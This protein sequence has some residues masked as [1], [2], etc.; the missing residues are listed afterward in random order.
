MNI[1]IAGASGFIG[2]ALISSLEDKHHITV[3]GRN[4]RKL[5]KLFKDRV[6]IS[7][8]SWDE[9]D[10]LDAHSFDAVINLCGHNISASRWN[11][12]VKALLISSRVQTSTRLIEWIKKQ[13]A[14]THIYSA[15]AVGIY[16]KQANF[17]VRVF[18]ESH[19]VYKLTADDFLN[20]IGIAWEQSLQLAKEAGIPLTITRF[21]VVLDKNHGMLK[22]LR[23]PF[24]MHLGS[25][26]GTGRQVISWIHIDDLVRAY[27]FL[28][29]SPELT[30][31]FNLCSPNPLSQKAFAETFAKVL[32]R[33]LFLKIPAFLIRAIFGEMGDCLLLNGQRVA[34]KRLLEEGFVFKYGTLQAAL[35]H[36]FDKP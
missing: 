13:S 31:C 34:P 5:Q 2:Q 10:A 20:H 6:K 23:L 24:S 15:S 26:L 7:T 33:S 9:L 36:E 30:G 11:K 22:K 8:H 12:R 18:D 21:G 1:L 17:D 32:H 3:L 19:P 27:E 25:I 35:E 16:G 28:L 4:T 29:K 14:K